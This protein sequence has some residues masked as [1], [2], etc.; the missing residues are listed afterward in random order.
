M[1]IP[2]V[3]AIFVDAS[4]GI[5][6]ALSDFDSEYDYNSEPDALGIPNRTKGT[7]GLRELY[8][9]WIDTYLKDIETNVETWRAQARANYQTKY[10]NTGWLRQFDAGDM[11]TGSLKFPRE[12]KGTPHGARGSWARSNY[13]GLWTGPVGPF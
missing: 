3:W 7:R 5:E 12:I 11:R 10:G 1:K 8:C 9:Y 2:A 13:Q 4:K 6:Q